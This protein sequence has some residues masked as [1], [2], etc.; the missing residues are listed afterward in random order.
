V[1][2]QLKDIA[3]R[4]VGKVLSSDATMRV[5]SSPQLQNVMMTALNL[6]AEAKDIVEKQVREVA[7]ALEL[8]T[9]EDVAKLRRSIRDLEDQV[10]DLQ[11]QLHDAHTQATATPD[12]EPAAEDPAPKRGRRG[13]GGGRSRGPQG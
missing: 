4:Q 1:L 12:G 13:P 2:N 9:R 5:L 11:T 8:V 6:R 10:A 3:A 7:S